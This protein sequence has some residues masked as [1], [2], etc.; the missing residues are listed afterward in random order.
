MHMESNA[1]RFVSLILNSLLHII[2]YFTRHFH[3]LS[4]LCSYHSGS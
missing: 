1:T 2:S 4:L 3:H